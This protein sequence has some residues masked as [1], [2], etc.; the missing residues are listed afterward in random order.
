MPTVLVLTA[1]GDDMEF[2]AGGTIA[3]LCLQGYDVHLVMATDNTKGTFELS[4]EQMYG[5][6]LKEAEAA[7]K[8]LGLKSVACLEYPDGELSDVPLNTLRRQ[9]IE[10]IRTIRPDIVFTFDPWAPYEN[11]QDHR[12]VSW[13]AMEATSFAHFPLYEPQQLEGG[14][15]PWLVPEVYYFAKSPTNTNVAV[16]T[17]GAPMQKQIEALWCYE[18]QMV[19]TVAEAQ[20]NIHAAPFDV[21]EIT[22][23][24]PH[25]YRDFI[26]KRVRATAA[27]VGRKYGFEFGEH[28][29][30]TRW[31]GTERFAPAGSVPPDPF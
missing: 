4:Y 20:M 26:E 30:R 6:R 8:V 7:A 9:F 21:P 14:L 29:R 19:L 5:L 3:K 31:S 22:T 16:D 1:H 27:A 2:F 12:A 17:S 15:E 23:L 11:H 10:A 25:D 24:D 18:S 13:A 28:F